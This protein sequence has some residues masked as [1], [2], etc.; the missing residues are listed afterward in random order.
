MVINYTLV[1]QKTAGLSMKKIC[2][3]MVPKYF[4]GEQQTRQEKNF[5]ARLL[6]RPGHLENQW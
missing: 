5:S 2:V 1:V 6:E 3:E 4:S